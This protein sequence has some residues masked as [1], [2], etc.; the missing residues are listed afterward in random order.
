MIRLLMKTVTPCLWYDA[1]GRDAAEFYARAIPDSRILRSAVMQGSPSGAVEMII[2]EIAGTRFDMM[3]AGPYTSF[4]PAV[5]FLLACESPD[6]VDT[7]WEALS[8][9]GTIMMELG[10]YDFSR[11]YGW[12]ADRFGVSWQ[13][14]L[15][16]EIPVHGRLTPTLMFTGDVAGQAEEAIR[17]YASLFP[18]SE[19][20]EIL[21]WSGSV[22]SDPE[23]SV[24][25]ASFTLTGMPFAAMDSAHP[26]QFGFTEAISFVARCD[27]QRE[28]DSLWEQL[29]AVPDAEQCG[30]LKDS[31]GISWQIIP[32]VLDKMLF[33]GADDQKRRVTEAFLKMKKMNIEEL[34]RAFSG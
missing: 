23:G 15:T 2:A 7:L 19:V 22:T 1:Q 21:R 9:D 26:H 14:M 27:S 28:I 6:E 34:E 30:W 8:S 11:R 31:Y 25:H 16:G 5:S 12:V 17:F 24:K 33:D 20:G 32:T 10:P 29:S 4:T 13:I 3:S 18:E